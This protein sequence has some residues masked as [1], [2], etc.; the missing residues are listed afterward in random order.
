MMMMI[1]IIIIIIIIDDGY[2]SG[3]V[4]RY[5]YVSENAPFLTVL[6]LHL[7]VDGIF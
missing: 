4:H 1:I 3:P 6:G 2:G 7:H 5:P